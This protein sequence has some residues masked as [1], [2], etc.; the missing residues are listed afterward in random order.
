MED[1]VG[2]IRVRWDEVEVS[3]EDEVGMT[4]EAADRPPTPDQLQSLTW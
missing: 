4:P 3:V 1:E 2:R